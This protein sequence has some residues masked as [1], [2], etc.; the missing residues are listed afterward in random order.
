M[1]SSVQL[2]S[3][4]TITMGYSP[5]MYGTNTRTVKTS[6]RSVQTSDNDL[7]PNLNRISIGNGCGHL[8]GCQGL[9]RMYNGNRRVQTFV[10]I[11]FD[12]D[13]QAKIFQYHENTS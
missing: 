10:K 12:K 3:L 9:I 11:N 7:D 2:T 13:V 8:G 5:L 6:K 1:S 4:Y